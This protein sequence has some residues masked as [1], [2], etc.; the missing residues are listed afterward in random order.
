MV[1]KGYIFMKNAIYIFLSITLTFLA[2]QA[3]SCRRSAQY[4]DANF[5]SYLDWESGLNDEESWD[6]DW[7]EEYEEYWD[8]DAIEESVNLSQEEYKKLLEFYKENYDHLSQKEK[9]IINKQIGQYNGQIVKDEIERAE[10]AV[11][12]VGERIPSI[13]E[14]F[15]SVFKK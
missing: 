9:D 1:T 4:E 8:E 14:G 13:V 10:D 15:V 6:E 11:K 12:K 7:E 5:D 2:L 3:C